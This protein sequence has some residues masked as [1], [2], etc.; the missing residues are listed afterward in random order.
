MHQVTF[1]V[2]RSLHIIS[3]DKGLEVVSGRT[4]S[5]MQGRAYHLVLPRIA[6]GGEDAIECSIRD[7]RRLEFSDYRFP[8]IYGEVS[9]E[10]QITPVDL[11]ARGAQGALVSIRS[12]P[13]CTI[14]D[15]LHRS[16]SLIDIGKVA[17]T[18]A[19]GVRNPLNAIKGGV[20]YL[21]GKYAEES[22]LVEFADMMEEEIERLDSFITRFLSTSF[23]DNEQTET[24]LNLLLKKIETYTSLQASALGMITRF[25]CGPI[26]PVRINLFQ[27]EQAFLNIV[28]NAMDAMARGGELTVTSSTDF[29]DGREFAVVDIAD[30]GPGM[31]EAGLVDT[32]VPTPGA[33]KGTGRGFGLFIAREVIQHHGGRLEIRSVK[34]AGT[35]VRVC[36]PVM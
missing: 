34:G 31:P 3:W 16:Q 14:A 32:P 36:L 4:S 21:K 19:H 1:T 6:M 9:A 5:Q 20:V 33:V 12:N 15:R 8:C 25:N 23:F 11:E 13:C 22:T 24:D 10:I 29:I 17:S 26:S 28:N 30:T 27:M 2:D 18:L 7:G 35:T